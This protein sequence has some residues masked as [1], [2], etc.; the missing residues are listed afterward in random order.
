MKGMRSMSRGNLLVLIGPSGCGKGTVL[1]EV[2]EA[3]KNT[4]YSISATTRPPRPGEENGKHYYFISKD[5]FQDLIEKDGLLE[6]ASYVGNYY[7]TPK[8]AVL[9]RLDAGE[10]VILEIEV[11]GAKQV[12]EKYPEA[13]LIFILPP[14]LEELRS[15]LLGRKTE[16][17]ETVGRRLK[18]AGEEMEFARE[19]DYV[20][21]NDRVEDAARRL[22]CVI[23]SLPCR[24]DCMRETVESV[25][26]NK[27]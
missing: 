27:K 2:L 6:Y 11:Q 25:L 10:N 24:R 7:G 1:K 18:K 26:R 13:V 23:E 14:S 8:E 15:R 3:E 21:L 12:R 16:D 9:R 19:C 5:E 20:I 4:F 17:E 22:C